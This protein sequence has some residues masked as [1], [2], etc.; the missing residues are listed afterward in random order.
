MSAPVVLPELGILFRADMVRA[1]LAGEKTETRRAVKFGTVSVS[2][3]ACSDQTIRQTLAKPCR[4]APGRR[5]WVRETWRPGWAESDPDGAWIT[6]KAD[7]AVLWQDADR[8]GIELDT[9]FDAQ[10]RHPADHWRPSILMPRWASR[11]NLRV[12][13]IRVERLADITPAGVRAEG[14]VHA[15][16]GATPEDYGRAYRQMHKLPNTANPFVWVVTFTR[17]EPPHAR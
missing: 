11:T 2:P 4:Y 14:F 16:L 7:D 8:G 6:Y 9:W 12:A 13:A 1:I 10:S 5:L 3:L 15:G 17:E